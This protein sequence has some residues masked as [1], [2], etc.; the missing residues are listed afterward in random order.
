MHSSGSESY[1]E[2]TRNV[3]NEMQFIFEQVSAEPCASPSSLAD[4]LKYV[5]KPLYIFFLITQ[6]RVAKHGIYCSPCLRSIKST[7]VFMNGQ[8]TSCNY[9]PNRSL[10]LTRLSFFEAY[11]FCLKQV[12]SFMNNHLL[13]HEIYIRICFC[14]ES[15][16]FCLI[17]YEKKQKDFLQIMQA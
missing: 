11:A 9:E 17:F 10:K 5:C 15:K 8:Y 3:H 16:R 4:A 7:L 6:W 13:L 12:V 14:S 1:N 2:G